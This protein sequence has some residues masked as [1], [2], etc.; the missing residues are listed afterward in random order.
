[1]TTAAVRGHADRLARAGYLTLAVDLFSDGGARRC[2]VSTMR[3]IISGSGRA[4]TD[5]AW[6]RLED[7][8][9][10]HLKAPDTTPA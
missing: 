1:M 5:Q 10:R 6:Q 3:Y 7:H 9:A 2:L 4:F 8:F